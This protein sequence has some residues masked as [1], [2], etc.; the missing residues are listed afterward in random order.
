[1]K[2]GELKNDVA[3]RA[4]LLGVSENEVKLSDAAI[5]FVTV[6]GKLITEMREKDGLSYSEIAHLIGLKDPNIIAQFESGQL[7]HAVDLKSLAK[8]AAV[9]GYDLKIEAIKSEDDVG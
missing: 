6:V 8:I 5:D 4:K 9:L 3:S 2:L 1:M 7:R